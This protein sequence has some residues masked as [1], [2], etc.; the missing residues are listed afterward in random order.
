MGI[1]LVLL[2]FVPA[3]LISAVTV[4]E[5]SRRESALLLRDRPALDWRP[6]ASG[7]R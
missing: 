4:L 6:P 1:D 3:L 5:V 7:R 2:T